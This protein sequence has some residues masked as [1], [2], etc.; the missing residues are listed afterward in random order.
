MRGTYLIAVCDILGFSALVQTNPLADVVENSVAW[1]RRALNH[2]VLKGEFP[3]VP[4]PT[5]QLNAHEH[6]G[7]AWFSD[8]ILFYTKQDTDEAIRE[9]LLVIGW[10]LF[11]TVLEG[12]TKIRAGIAYG[13]AHIDQNNSMY[14]GQAIVDAYNLEKVQQWAGAA[15][16]ES[17]CARVPEIARSGKFADWWVT[18]WEVPLKNGK[19]V[20]TLAVNWNWGVHRPDWSLRWSR[21]SAMPT[22]EAWAKDASLCEKFVNTKRFHEAHCRDCQIRR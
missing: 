2:A 4:P 14:V 9:L 6:V 20:S 5:T 15:L 1:F 13:E 11:E 18:P 8:T 12:T 3:A 16:T 19:T 21:E 7:V 10:L 22:P 17:A